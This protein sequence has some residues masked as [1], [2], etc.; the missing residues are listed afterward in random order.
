MEDQPIEVWNEVR[1]SGSSISITL[2]SESAGSTPVV[3]DE[4]WFTFDELQGEMV[5]DIV[6]LRLSEE[7]RSAM[8]CTDEQDSDE[9]QV[10][11][12]V[13]DDNPPSWSHDDNIVEVVE[14]LDNV[15]CDQYIIQSDDPNREG[16]Q[17]GGIFFT[18]E[19][20]ADANPSYSPD[21][22][23][24]LAVYRDDNDGDVYAFPEGRLVDRLDLEA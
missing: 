13:A 19:T 8:S 23:V 16:V 10:G 7:T 2:Y 1:L 14:V 21:E 5:G 9:L 20:V 6:S 15:T 12:V 24:V 4:A 18:E 11:D 3:E 22:T 17:R